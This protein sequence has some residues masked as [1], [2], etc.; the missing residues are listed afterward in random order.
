MITYR[1]WLGDLGVSNTTGWRWIRR[2]WILPINV[3]G[4]LYVSRAAIDMFESRAGRGGFAQAAKGAAVRTG[5][6]TENN[7]ESNSL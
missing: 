6:P 2:G 3:A 1:K 7:K 4:R 5:G